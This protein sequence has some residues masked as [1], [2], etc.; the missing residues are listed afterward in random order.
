MT[1]FVF[2]VTINLTSVDCNTNGVLPWFCSPIR[3]CPRN[4]FCRWVTDPGFVASSMFLSYLTLSYGL[5][6]AAQ[7]IVS[8]SKPCISLRLYNLPFLFICIIDIS[9]TATPISLMFFPWCSWSF[10]FLISWWSVKETSSACHG[11]YFSIGTV[12]QMR[13]CP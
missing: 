5:P 3:T 13:W 1:I 12:W 10:C 7:C 6:S 8:F 2:V 4:I 9:P 11:P